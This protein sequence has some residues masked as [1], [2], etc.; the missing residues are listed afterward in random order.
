MRRTP[1][2]S[3]QRGLWFAQELLPEVPFTIAQYVELRGDLDTPL[4]R[5]AC[6]QAARDVESGFLFLEDVGG[7]PYQ[8]VRVDAPD[9]VG[10][11]DLRGSEDPE[12]DAH[13]WMEARYSRRHDPMRDRLIGTT[14]LQLADDRF[15]LSSHVHHI[16]LDGHGAMVMLERS[17][18]LYTA[19][20]CGDE[21]PPVRSLPVDRLTELD[22]AY[23]TS[24]RRLRDREHWAPRLADLPTPVSLADGSAPPR[25]PCRHTGASLEPSVA[26]AVAA[27]A[28]E[29]NS[30]DV[31]VV[32]AAFAA[33]LARTTGTSDVVLSLPV[34]ARTTAA[35]RRSGG[36]LSNVVPL[37]LF[38]H[39][40]CTPTELIRQ[41]QLELTGALRHQRYRY[42]DMLADLRE[43]GR[44]HREVRSAFGP[45][46]NLM[47]FH[48]Q[49]S[50]GDIVGDFH[51][52]STGPIDDLSVNV[53]PGIAGRTV[54]VDFEANPALYSEDSLV[55][56]HRR[57]VDHLACFVTEPNCAVG[58]LPFTDAADPAGP[59]PT[60]G[61][62]AAE[63]ALLPE[64]LTAHA[65]SDAVAVRDGTSSL[66]Y[67][68]L[69]VRSDELACRLIA[70]GAGPEDRVAVLLHRSIDSVVALWAVAKT[71]AAY[72]PIDPD[73][74]AT[75]LSEVLRSVTVAIAGED[76]DL[77]GH[78]AVVSPS[79]GPTGDAAAAVEPPRALHVDHPAW[80]IHTSGS[81][82][83]PKAVAVTHR[84]VA[85]LVATLREKY[86]ADRE[87]RVL[88]LAAPTF[89]ASLQ[90]LLLA[91]DV[92]ATA[93]IC[94][95]DAVAGPP[96][97]DLLRR[98]A[99]THAITAPAI[100][101]VTPE[102]GLPGLRVVDSG[103]EALPQAV[104]DRWSVGRVLLNAY[105]P[106]ET[107][108]L[109]TLSEPLQPG[110]GV[111]IGRPIHGTAA[112]VLDSRL[113][114]V[115]A[116]VVGELY[117]AG[118]SVAR[119][120]LDA[121]A[122]TAER[123]VAGPGGERIY[124]TGDRVRWT[125]E[126]GTAEFRL[127]FL[128]RAD[129]QVQIR[130]RRIE[131]GEIETVLASF[132]DIAAAVVVVRGDR[133]DAYVVGE[134]A[135]AVDVAD[136]TA[137]LAQR[138]PVHLRPATT[139][140]LGTLP[141]TPGG[142]VDRRAL[143][144]PAVEPDA[145]NRLPTGPD[146]VLV[147]RLFTER[148][149]A[150]DV[151]ADTDFFAV[152]G[153]S[154]TATQLASD[155]TAALGRDI[156]LRDVFEH[157]TV[158]RLAAAATGRPVVVP[159]ER[160]SAEADDAH[161][162]PGPLAPAQYR[163]WLQAR[164]QRDTSAY[165][166]PFALQL[167]GDLDVP[168]LRIALGDV[169]IRHRVLRTVFPASPLG[170]VQR[171]LPVIEALT[172]FD[173]V[174]VPAAP[175]DV[176]AMIR[177]WT[178]LPFDLAVD[179]PVR[180]RLLQTGP[181]R[182]VLVVVAHHIA[183]DGAS[184]V[185]LTADLAA[186]YVARCHGDAP[187]W[188]PLPLHYLDH[189]RAHRELLG[190]P[191]D[192][193]G[194]A[195]RELE[196]WTGAL[197]GLESAPAVPT[198]HPRTGE[199][200]P[201]AAVPFSVPASHVAA[202]RG[203]AARHDAT[204]FMAV[205]AA[206]AVWLS[207]WTG[208]RDVVIG[209]G[210]AGRDHPD[211]AGLVGMFV[212]TVALRVTVDPEAAFA[213]LLADVRTADIDGFAHASVPFD[214]VV[215][216]LGFGP[217]AV[218]LSYDNI[219]PTTPV[220]P[221]LDVQVRE[222]DSVRARFDLE[223]QIRET[224]DGSLTGRLVY[225]SSLF[226]PATA[227]R[228]VERL[229]TVIA[230]VA[231][232]RTTAVG[233]IDLG[234]VPVVLAPS[235]PVATLAHLLGGSPARVAAPG[236][237]PVEIHSAARPMAWELLHR[238]IGPEDRVAVLLPRSVQSVLATAAVALTGAVFVPVDVHQPAAR[239][240][241]LLTAAGV[242]HVIAEPGT[243]VPAGIETISF[244]TDGCVREI[245]DADRT[246]PLHPDQAAYLVYTSGSTGRPKGVV[247]THRGLA[248]LARS[249][250]GRFRLAPDARVLHF[251]APAFDASVLEYLLALASGGTL[252]VA[253]ADVFGGD[254]LLELLRAERITH[255]FSTPSV[256]A[257]L[258]PDG[259][260][261]LRVLAVG[262]EA[263]Q[264]ETA[265]RWAPGRTMLNVYGPTETTVLATA[266]SPLAPGEP[267][268]LGT[269]L[270][271]VTPIVL[272][273]RLRPVPVG[274]TG[275]LY[276]I[277][278]GLA[279]GYLDAPVQTAERFPAA[280]FGG[281]RMY[282]TG[283]L[284]RWTLPPAAENP[285]PVLE[286]VGRADHQVK[287]R[288]FRIEPGEI[289]AVLTT[290][291]AVTTAVTVAHD[292]KLAAFVYGSG[293]RL[294]AT[295]IRQ[296][297]ATRL[298]RHMVPTT[299]TVLD[300]VPLTATGKIDRAALPVADA[301]ATPAGDGYRT[302]TEHLVATVVADVLGL[303]AVA[304]S[305]DFFALGGNSL[306]ATQLAAR[307]AG[308]VDRRVGVREI[309]ENPVV[310][311]LA[312]AITH[313]E[314]ER[315]IPLT[316]E[317]ADGP[318]P[319]APAQQRMWLVN[320]FDLATGIGGD[321]I[322]FVAELDESVDL[323]ALTAA[324]A[325]VVGRHATLRTV[326]P[327]G[328]D[329]PYRREL[330]AIT[331]DLTPVGAPADLDDEIADFARCPF[332]LTVAPPVRTRLYR[333]GNR[334]TLAVV[335]HH[336]AADGLSLL[337][338]GRDAV[339]A[340]TARREGTIP[341]WPALP[342]T[343]SDYARWQH[344]MLGAPTDPDGLGARQLAYW[345]RT[346]DGAS[347]LLPLPTDRPRTAGDIHADRITFA[348]PA[349]VHAAVDE[350][351]RAHDVTPFMVVH[352]ALAVLL[353][354]LAASDD[355]IVGTPVSGRTDAALD[356]VV[357]M[358]V[359]TVPLRLRIDPR[360]TFAELLAET[361]RVDLDAFAHAE[362]PFDRIVDAVGVS[363][364][365]H[366][367]LFRVIL[368]YESFDTGARAIPG[369]ATV[370]ELASDTARVDVE[371]TLRETF[372]DA[373]AA[374]GLDG[375]L[376]Y[377]SGL[378]DSGTVTTWVSWLRRI[379]DMVTSDPETTVGAVDPVGPTPASEPVS[380][381]VPH[382]DARSLSELFVRRAAA[383]PDAVAVA[384]G[385]TA[386]TYAQLRARSGALAAR[387]AERG[388][389]PEDVV[390]VALPRSVDLI[391]AIVAV[392]RCGA[393]YLP[394]DI[395]HPEA[396]LRS[397]FDDAEPVS[398]LCRSDFRAAGDIPALDPATVPVQDRA[399]ADD[400]HDV[401]ADPDRGAY[402]IYTSGSTGTPKGVLVSHRSALSVFAATT[403]RF[404]F[405]ESDVWTMFHSPAFDFSVW[406]MWGA[407]V[408]GGRLVVVDHA[409]VRDP[410]GFAALLGEHGVT[411]LNQ[412]PT[413]FHQ[414]SATAALPDSV[415]LVIFGGEPL[416]AE[417]VRS[418]Q[419]KQP[420][421]E[422]VNM[423]GITETAVH[424]TCGPAAVPGVGEPLP[425]I[426]M[427]LLD[428]YLRPVLPGSTG[429]IYVTGKQLAR[430]YR[431]RPGLTATRFVAAPGGARRYRSG[432]LG[433]R[434]GN[435]V[436][437]LGRADQ[438]IVLRGYRIE[439]GEI[440][441]ALLRCPGVTDAAVI[442]RDD[443]L[444]A[445]LVG[446]S[447]ADALH[448][449]RRTLP[450]HL[451]P[452]AAVVL[453]ALPLTGNGKL[454]RASLPEPV[455]VSAGGRAPHGPIEEVVA[456]TFGE[457]LR[458]NGSEVALGADDNF[459]HLGGNS[460]LANRLAGRLVGIVDADITV[461][462]I[463]EAP[464]VAALAERIAERAGRPIARIP[465][466][467]ADGDNAPLSP[468]QRRLWF[469]NRFDPQSAAYNLPFVL[470]LDGR[471]DADALAAAVA[472]V[473]ERHRTLRTIYPDATRQEISPVPHPV[474]EA[475][476]VAESECAHEIREFCSAG[477]D[478]TV[479]RPVRIRLLRLAPERH[480]LVVVAHHIAADE[481]SLAPL[482]RDLAA[483]YTA[484]VGGQR[485]QFPPLPV[486]YTDFARW[487]HA[488]ADDQIEHWLRVLADLPDEA[489]L[490]GDRPHPVRPSGRAA[491]RRLRLDRDLSDRLV[492][493]GRDRHA[494]V[495]MVVHAAL[496]ALI[497]RHGA[498]RDIPIGTV[499]A[500]R[501]DPRL[502]DVV[503]MF[504]GTL[505]LRTRVEPGMR[506][507]ELLAHVRAV[508]LDA[509]THPDAPFETLVER[510]DPP[511][512][513]GRHPLFQVALSHRRSTVGDVCLPGLTATVT[514]AP[515]EHAKF[516]V[517][518]TVTE[519]AAE[520]ELEFACAADLYDDETVSAFAAR[521]E[522]IL[523]AAA[524][525]PD[526]QIDDID[527]FSV[528][529]GAAPARAV[530]PAAPRPQSLWRLFVAGAARAGDAVAVRDGSRELT[531]PR[532]IER[533]EDIAARLWA[534]GAR[535]G[536]VVACA[537][538]RSLDAVVAAWGIARL[539]AAP[540]FVDPAQPP[541]RLAGMLDA[542]AHGVAGQ[543]DS[544][545]ATVRW[546]GV[547]AAG[548]D[549]TGLAGL[550]EPHPDSPAYLVFTSG[551]TGNPKG[552]AV[553]HRA[554]TALAADLADRF[555][556]GPGDRVLHVAAPSFDAAVLELLV[557]GA[558]GA[559]LVVAGPDSYGGADLGELLARERI[560]HACLTPSALAS[561][562]A[563]A[564]PDLR[565]LMLGGE[566][567][568]GDLVDR[569]GAGRDLYNG[570]GPAEA[571][572]FA[573]CS[574]ALI[575]G[576]V[577]VIGNPV[578][579]VAVAVLDDRLQPVPVGVVGELYLSGE[580]L[581]VGYR[582]APARTAQRFVATD[583]GRMYRTGDRARWRRD[584]TLEYRGRSDSQVK[585]RGVRIEPG[586]VDAALRRVAGVEQAAT[587]VRDGSLVS[588]VVPADLDT[589]RVRSQLSGTLPGHLIPA[590]VVAL[591]AL[592]VTPHGKLDA[593]ALPA[594]VRRGDAPRT[595]TEML[596]ARV[597]ADV[598][599]G[600]GPVGRSDDFF[601]IGGNSLLA[602]VLVGRLR[603]ETGIAVPLRAVF[604]HPT[605]HDLA[606]VLDAGGFD[607]DAGPVA[608]MPRPSR[609]P[610]SRAQ[611]RLWGLDQLNP[612][613]YRLRAEVRLGGRLDPETLDA[614][615]GDVV[616]RHEILRTRYVPT[617]TDIHQEA[618]ARRPD[619]TRLLESGR[620][621]AP[622]AESAG[623]IRVE[624][625]RLEENL[626][627]LHLDVD[628]SLADGASLRPLLADL[629]DAY[630][631]RA[632]GHA[633]R[634]LPLPL[635]YADYAIW[636]HARGIPAADIDHWKQA[637][638][639]LTVTELPVDRTGEDAVAGTIEFAVPGTVREAVA[640]LA[641]A[642]GA[643][644]FMVVHAALSVLLARVG[645]QHDVAIA[646]VVS[647]R[648][649]AQLD[650]LVGPFVETL[651]LRAAVAPDRSFTELLATVR[652]F[653]VAALDHATVPYEQITGMLSGPRPQVALAM[654]DFDPGRVQFGDI[655]IEA[656]EIPDDTPKFDL[657]FTLA[658]GVD[659]YRAT[660][661]FDRSRFAD[662]TAQALVRR[663]T[664]ALTGLVA[665]PADP[666][667]DV[668]LDAPA[669]P[670]T[671]DVPAAPH[672][673]SDLLRA[674]AAAHPDREALRGDGISLTYR[675]LDAASDALAAEWRAA[676]I[677]PGTVVRLGDTRSAG[678]IRDL[679]A[680]TKTG[681]AFTGSTGIAATCPANV[682]YVVATSGSTGT[683]KQVAVT[684]TGLAPLAAEAATR[685]RVGPGDRVLQGYHPAFDAALLEVLL[686]H[687]T[688][689][690]LVVA[691]PDVYAGPELH[692]LLREERI[693]HYLSTPTVLG[694]LEPAGLHDLRVVA[695]G[696]ETLPAGIAERWVADRLLLD[697]YGP[698][699]STIVA[700][701]TEFEGGHGADR[702]EGGI[703]RPVPGTTAHV[704]DTRLQPVPVGA[705]GELYLMGAG[706][707]LGYL[708]AAPLTAERFVAAPG[709][710]RMYRTGDR[711]Q[712]RTDGTLAYLG[713]TDRQLKI[714]GV[715]IEPG[716]LE[717]ALLAAPGVRQAAVAAIDGAL[718]AFAAATGTTV[719]DL[720]ATVAAT[721]PSHR[722]PAR[723]RVVD[724][725]PVTA[726]G[727]LD[728]AALT[729]LDSAAVAFDDRALTPG[730]K[731]VVTI[732]EDVLGARPAA[733]LGF[734]A[735]G[736]DSLGAV[737]LAARLS[738][739]FATDVPT[740]A[741]LEA[742]SLIALAG[743]VTDGPAPRPPLRRADTTGPV[744][745]AP[746][747]RRLWLL[748]R[749]EPDARYI[750]PVVLRL[751]GALDADALDAAVRDL[752][753]RHEI[754]RTAYPD[755]EYA[756]VEPA[757]LERIS[758][759]DP[760]PAV[761]E[762]LS[763]PFDLG[764]EP[765]L[766]VRLLDIA[767][768]E[769]ILVAAVHHIAF[770]GGSV[771]P[772]LSDLQAAYVARAGGTAPAFEPL[773][774]TYR[775]YA[776]WQHTFLGDPTDPDSPAHRQLDYWAAA[777]AGAPGTPLPLPTDRPR[778]SRPSYRGGTTAV[779]LDA[780]F[781]TRLRTV[782]RAHDVT[783]FMLLHAILAALLARRSGRSDI[784]VGT[785]VAGRD[786]PR[787]SALVGM[788]V[789]TVA[790]RTP[791][792][793]STAVA[794]LLRDVRAADLGAL[795]H[796]DVPF[797]QVVERLAPNR[798]GAHH[799]LFQVMLT[800]RP[801]GAGDPLLQLPGV[802]IGDTEMGS[803]PALF[804]LSWEIVE[805]T[806]GDGGAGLDVRVVYAT[807]LFDAA[808]VDGLLAEYVRLLDA[809]LATPG[810]PVGDLAVPDARPL[811]TAEVTPR[812]LRDLL[813]GTVAAHPHRIAVQAGPV[814]WTYAELDAR[815]TR[816]ASE[817]AGRGVGRGDLVAVAVPRSE[818]WPLA[819]WAVTKAGAAWVSLDVSQPRARIETIL[820]DCGATFGLTVP[821]G[822]DDD[823]YGR[824]TV[825]WIDLTGSH[826]RSGR[827]EPEQ[828]VD[829]LAYVIYTSGTTGTPKGVAVPHRGL[830]ALVDVQARRLGLR[831]G[832]RVLQAISTTFDAA[833]LT[834][835]GAHA[836]GGTLVIADDDTI[837]GPALQNLLVES[838]IDHLDLT[839]TVLATL[840]P[841]ALRPVTVVAGGETLHPALLRRWSRHRI[842]NG[843]GPTEFTVMVSCAGP[844]TDTTAKPAVGLPVAG[845]TAYVLDARL[846]PVSP[847]TVGELYITGA[848]L[849]R[850]YHRRTG[851]TATRF[852][853]DPFGK[854][855]SRLYRTGDLVR[856]TATGELDHLGR[857]DDQVQIRG[858]RTEP[859]EVDA[860][861]LTADGVDAAVTVAIPGAD[862]TL[863]L[864]SYVQGRP[865]LPGLR[866][867]LASQLPRHLRPATVT[868]VDALPML[869]SGK[870]DR[871][872]LPAPD[873]AGSTEA[874]V[875]PSGPTGQLVAA[876]YARHLDIPVTAVSAD[877]GFFDLGGSSLG[878]VTVAGELSEA[879]GRRV[880]VGWLV[881]ARTVD[882][883]ARRIDSGVDPDGVAA[884]ATDPLAVLVPLGTGDPEARPLFCVHPIS[885][886]AWCYSGLAAHLDGASVY[887]LQ[888][889]GLDPIPGSI[890]ELAARYVDRIRAVQPDGPYHLL[891][892]SAGGTI[893]HEMAVQL[894]EA[895][896]R[897]ALLALLDTFTPETMPDV[898][899]P[900]YGEVEI[901]T[902]G[903]PD[904]LVAR[905]RRR[906]DTA[907]VTVETGLRH[908]TP[909]VHDGA[910]HL[911]V[912]ESERRDSAALVA[913]WS[914]YTTG[915]VVDHPL[916]F[917]HSD[918]TVPEALR[919]IGPVLVQH[920]E[921]RSNYHQFAPT[922]RSSSV[923][924]TRETP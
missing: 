564:L 842:F 317:V 443:R 825:E 888:A 499:V 632:A 370:R 233:D 509:Y 766:R 846:H 922:G 123:F 222:F 241:Q 91:F 664:A 839:P 838:R 449:V 527:L 762:T 536:D 480:L 116:G 775:D 90:E 847:G 182:H 569:W 136:V 574:A 78:V 772:L 107:T 537:L 615:I 815:A 282:R 446:G 397:L 324:T 679:W 510:L 906:A 56:H 837:A 492:R 250:V 831:P 122:L 335:L 598:L 834:V 63:P 900:A 806:T 312:D 410:A 877:H 387:L 274:V 204:T 30:T 263:W 32:V 810:R 790:L 586:E 603:E 459:F 409:T 757:V 382:A 183:L 883:L 859:A 753:D 817:L 223:L 844:L 100:L 8:T 855:G 88:H 108:V 169:V 257:R 518:V 538:P 143:P 908:H 208:E 575:P 477:F 506:F 318:Q 643:T 430:G 365:E 479:E 392:A 321:H 109:A 513:P 731:L 96:L 695:S 260:D 561:V 453:D 730:E 424:A 808:T 581:A 238:G 804:D 252:V 304:P 889:V 622:T 271:G 557:A 139:T 315:R 497:A 173:I 749:T 95:S 357:G 113:H 489:T 882:D 771:A 179:V 186:A 417:R 756:L 761:T 496:A 582:G 216:K 621:P 395:T 80:V 229:G 306:L 552:V 851:L 687:T 194:L 655:S 174:P 399:A 511:R 884:P 746:A 873:T 436:H 210:V 38:V 54:R 659:G 214:Q 523:H 865:D 829:E 44:E 307:L 650:D 67:R 752:C 33:F 93:V 269:G 313:T 610:L 835:L 356:D 784:V 652:A 83:V 612:G 890:P 293:D 633:P 447:A 481:W 540:M 452:S 200:G 606:A 765:P 886:L 251:A 864:A 866:R 830:T 7:Q 887:G 711:V 105:G 796:A 534:A 92:G 243:P 290:H 487:Q 495:F 398:V 827:P 638:D 576:D 714:R 426:G 378:F 81:T 26:E 145:G 874:Y 439:P 667:G 767:P 258:D 895:G 218:M 383:A 309:L 427:Q 70:A 705:V 590:V 543:Q 512:I 322:A 726:N 55:R 812:T 39:P 826:S 396:R 915:D 515:D 850:G 177:Q 331:L 50:F 240:A 402:L 677:G 788:F 393:V 291:P 286:F 316:H 206:V 328:P 99:I 870:V 415:R 268:N 690:T 342:V 46:V 799:P 587:V 727:K 277:G 71:G 811:G 14:V 708:D 840:D 689:A 862:G 691:P 614:A 300:E 629:A 339:T 466:T 292:G 681:A 444:V 360:G 151:G 255:W 355:V 434:A 763:A 819:L 776:R 797:E 432:D 468:A 720:T 843:Y 732:A 698:T 127:E 146:E 25:V 156:R 760:D 801:G 185:P 669:A 262:G 58:D 180:I 858:I 909:R 777:L 400:D 719:D 141:L 686:A 465:L 344:R 261:D 285:D 170:P 768:G 62:G 266:G 254:E 21:P 43:L 601:T 352:A 119:G 624:L 389:G 642:H 755:G 368:A 246:R 457:L 201:A 672:T 634:W 13:R 798:D 485:P 442:L 280:P 451:V 617:G 620:V 521:L 414:L 202:L 794:D 128:G 539:G 422:T 907:A 115:P 665:A 155:L 27:L 795:A 472:D 600:A 657:Q 568:A 37:R 103:G 10:F 867:Q 275:E 419:W 745:I 227:A 390:A 167:D 892:W 162:D 231:G 676:G 500:G 821:H 467:A 311:D 769:S 350:L 188:E 562:P 42:E 454:D 881:D 405:D 526:V 816:I 789:G 301:A 754:L 15:F 699:E 504:A 528:G 625:E 567:V 264:P 880:P 553:G 893:A 158:S 503:G 320:R 4:I 65:G 213:A 589:G 456:D 502:D 648:R 593:A 149:G 583:H 869:P 187:R 728:L 64:L 702:T 724:Q 133:L 675:E 555:A 630:L 1:L 61:S 363:A 236:H 338:L 476:A 813:A 692:R 596:V 592:P 374:A 98:E 259:L 920:G 435:T 706:L 193:A 428:R 391:V 211:L 717:T 785:A 646:A 190:D 418:W 549:T 651:V 19:W 135:A 134:E 547:P 373:G 478:L 594:P 364:A 501:G 366:H 371:I 120:Y 639:G 166:L 329:G 302:V 289:D 919:R 738:E 337:P 585:L 248:P 530:G 198:D 297:A 572:V 299:V 66:T 77:P 713:R 525:D 482:L 805:H 404:G 326:H 217:F 787:L 740:R 86:R 902:G 45:V 138:L 736:G 117:L 845:A 773:P 53:Y 74:P 709:G 375:T 89:D 635:Q 361:R 483:A 160:R 505:V 750:V 542:V 636:E 613:A 792:D 696:G 408:T 308:I 84:G 898:T 24:E 148:T 265:A 196:Y 533:A 860:V 570:Y 106:T 571:T 852:V 791:V 425:G 508:D 471:L 440:E 412:T 608:V 199:P 87:S 903:L 152:G 296:Y 245:T 758:C 685:Y 694:T 565:V 781:H 386:L 104:A 671:G 897:V 220:L 918:L 18:E 168:A 124:R 195:Y 722:M 818:Y 181:D 604:D 376:T 475:I 433:R 875:P 737:V 353:A 16:A 551:T 678:R 94:P 637:L 348:V 112:H 924:G 548:A 209:T 354:A 310:A 101:S 853:A 171:V 82:G 421:I 734:I 239:I 661:R 854:P 47:M 627:V 75:R 234:A 701:L 298:P 885:G 359:G 161:P 256:P 747:Q 60:D 710:Q 178:A 891:G 514:P 68:E 189:A 532:L 28:S 917:A 159:A 647:T 507:A 69:D 833:I 73:L 498:G 380:E 609:I 48:P 184:F 656:R 741:V 641:R 783:I 474:L 616:D 544:L 3:V 899:E 748:S 577:P 623:P 9:S 367:P 876:V 519:D 554:V 901:D 462:D 411:V 595:E 823:E 520:L 235:G 673:L 72:T 377:A 403:S 715:R 660:L 800:H 578:R 644:E 49:I 780:Q 191:A 445:Y 351:A 164:A 822:L 493:L 470:S 814:A 558:S 272:D 619:T 809:A 735:A 230:S 461:R 723:I 2:S 670:L 546:I 295:A 294:D 325:D 490:P 836:H 807:D 219:P 327:D 5:K 803:F 129:R 273:R 868:V 849:A 666:V 253:P 718:V 385:D 165:H 668:R 653:D 438:Q 455:V 682:A 31:P 336:I 197:A 820:A 207:A 192:P 384:D 832:T 591:A 716:E 144:V 484:R 700:T 764:C 11:V 921:F 560:T 535:T 406:E 712:Q 288:G 34:S 17:A 841:D 323:D 733:H 332:D 693:T 176:E 381:P 663:F 802:D 228:W 388:I 531:Y 369:L 224:G 654:Q 441:A 871:A 751:T 212:G 154:L 279:R 759:A 913:A 744:P 607:V 579:G 566:T 59:V 872:A 545:P 861:L 40:A 283:D 284:V 896:Q 131:P 786:D 721:V 923:I 20:A 704:L 343:Y 121:P 856:V 611:R 76:T 697:A 132:A 420:Q 333:N 29:A 345:K 347:P 362:V 79:I 911:F 110:A 559:T 35:L 205:H 848:G 416:D 225:D 249:L 914:R 314:A 237:D 341:T 276:L 142:K 278:A 488:I 303:A 247:V 85:S 41:V 774:V 894:R 464:T 640:S 597:C 413:A 319:L 203:V 150:V 379:L 857:D 584:G 125:S 824:G 242:G 221:G 12:G 346:L 778:P 6:E 215:E 662:D 707:A 645:D 450:D 358:F 281:G 102:T 463:F 494:T 226:E 423:Y 910:V 541:A 684:H 739:A 153:H 742:P 863:C 602:T 431:G 114:P 556:A 147:A 770:D 460:L 407:L 916:P 743:S 372:S 618:S 529:E 550:P 448:E 516:D 23:R 688:G 599:G 626:H 458:D 473:L 469:V 658:P 287:I 793:P 729:E 175:D 57:F 573:T 605:V 779:H 782:A 683:P 649:W 22:A 563:R 137:R 491:V 330:P 878:A 828:S 674:A 725:L 879:L 905:V 437:H 36:A 111:P 52:Q 340:Y 628:H 267:L 232:D 904:D 130:G 703:G 486:Q 401:P 97:A 680:A 349:D 51:V 517:Q 244:V 140:V 912:A 172:A 588:Y 631:A 163:L 394:V 522:A 118:P 580:R 524:G 270:E 334:Y 126:P 157:P 305:D 429:E